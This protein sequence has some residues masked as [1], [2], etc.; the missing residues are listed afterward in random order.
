MA[1]TNLSKL[2]IKFIEDHV[3]D[4]GCTDAALA[5]ELG[6]SE[7]TIKRC[8]DK[9]GLK[10]GG[11]GK[12]HPDA[13]N[14]SDETLNSLKV[15][16]DDKRVAWSAKFKLTSRYKKIKN[17][18]NDHEVEFFIN[19]WADYH[20]QFNDM[21]PSEEDLLEHMLM[22]QVRLDDNHRQ[23]RQLQIYEEH[24]KA[25]FMDKLDKELD[26]ENENDRR[27]HE[28]LMSNNRQLQ[29]LNKELKDLTERYEKFQRAFAGTREQREQNNKVGGE[30]F[31]TLLQEFN[32]REF[33]MKMGRA[34]EYMKMATKQQSDKMK[35]IH[36]FVD[37][38]EEPILLDGGDFIKKK[39]ITNVDP[40]NKANNEEASGT[41][42][43]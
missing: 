32:K 1:K 22:V 35:N 40:A 23:R 4:G 6:R 43:P 29:D 41:I 26:L 33:R 15:S 37:G 11:G 42:S 39:E 14:I 30:T 5:K 7:L 17:A 13:N 28:M 34:N 20:V 31:M 8:R 36:K 18:L 12:L 27:L 25:Q 9:L 3:L 2:E 38:S 19:Q 24:L 10:K 21:Q 16:D